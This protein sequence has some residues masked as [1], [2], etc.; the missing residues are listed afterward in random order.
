MV[1]LMWESKVLDWVVVYQWVQFCEDRFVI[2]QLEDENEL[3]LLLDSAAGKKLKSAMLSKWVNPLTNE[4]LPAFQ[5]ILYS[6]CLKDVSMQTEKKI[7]I[8][9]PKMW[10][11]KPINKKVYGVPANRIELCRFLITFTQN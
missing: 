10:G 2:L 6:L 11:K 9:T 5:S 1:L 7:I 4:P 3:L 8:W